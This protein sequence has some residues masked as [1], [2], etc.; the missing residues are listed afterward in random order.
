MGFAIDL[1]FL[2]I[3]FYNLFFLTYFPKR[4]ME[5]ICVLFFSSSYMDIKVD[6]GIKNR[7]L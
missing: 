6:L 2:R 5:T 1:L 4:E 7:F 3:F